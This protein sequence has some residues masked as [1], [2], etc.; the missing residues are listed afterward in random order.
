MLVKSA[1]PIS[2]QLR[3][4][5]ASRLQAMLGREV[6]LTS[7]VDPE[8]LGG[9]VVRVGDTVYDGSL[10][11]KLKSMEAVTL[12]QATQRLRE[13]PAAIALT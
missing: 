8:L 3:Q 12:E 10:A 4:S 5:I 1:A 6:V 13:S 11:G 9:L 2:N 7:E